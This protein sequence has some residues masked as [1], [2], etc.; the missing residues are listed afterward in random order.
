MRGAGFLPL[1]S[2]TSGAHLSEVLRAMPASASRFW[3]ALDDLDTVWILGPNPPQALL[4]AAL[5][6][7]RRRRLVLGVRQNL[8]ELIRHRHASRR[9]LR[10]AASALEAAWRALALLVPVVVVGPD[11][12]QRYR[13]AHA[14]HVTY[15][16]L[17]ADAEI[18]APA[19]DRRALRRAGAADARR[20]AARRGEEPAAVG[21]SAR[22]GRRQRPPLAAP[23]LW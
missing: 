2:Y 8:P 22:A 11:L 10:S 6:L 23:H 19:D 12:A 4:F 3:R 9:L 7:L 18:T 13:R 20:R 1:P 15:V 21:G 5:T 14:V 16:S 17:L